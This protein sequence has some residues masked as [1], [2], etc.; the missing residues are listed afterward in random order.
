M[1][2]LAAACPDTQFYVYTKQFDFVQKYIDERGIRD[3]LVI[4]ISEWKDNTK[5]YNFENLNR[6]VWDDGD[7]AKVAALQHCPAIAK[8]SKPGAKGKATHITCEQCGLCWRKNTGK[9]IAVYNH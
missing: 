2:D 9:R 8:P 7:D 6:F 1:D 5:G 4:N 3:N